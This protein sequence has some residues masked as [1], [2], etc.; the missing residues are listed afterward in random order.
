MF[1]EPIDDTYLEKHFICYGEINRQPIDRKTGKRKN[2]PKVKIG[3]GTIICPDAVVY[4]GTE[5]GE[6]CFI[7]DG[8]SI[9]E[10]CK[11]GNNTLIGRMSVI[12]QD[13]VIG[14]NVKINSN[15][16]ITG[17][18]WIGDNCFFG[19][20]VSTM[21][22]T[23]MG[24]DKEVKLKGPSISYNVYI[25]GGA[26]ILPGIVITNNVIIGAGALI[27]KSI[28]CP[29]TVWGSVPAVDI[30]SRVNIKKLFPDFFEDL[31]K[32]EIRDY[33]GKKSS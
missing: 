33:H 3:K 6:N 10:G 14:N 4:A 19:P 15:V 20:F 28:H 2:L 26:T 8:A 21:N 17:N 31:K 12:E 1:D 27:T 5:I 32:N 25:G 11:I 24:I 29:Y 30:T 16:H 7:A 23:Y 13:V 9:R 18:M 22:D